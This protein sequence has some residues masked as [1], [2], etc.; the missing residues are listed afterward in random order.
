M[1]TKRIRNAVFTWN[2]Y[3][4]GSIDHLD[5]LQCKYLVYGKEV[6]STGTKHL[7]GY[8]EFTKQLTFGNAKKLLPCCHIEPRKG[9][10]QQAADY[11][12]KDGDYVERGELSKPGKRN[13]LIAVMDKIKQKRKF[14]EI[15]EEHPMTVARHLKF[16]DRYRLEVARS[17]NQF[18]PIEV[19]VFWGPA[20]SGKTKRAY[21]MDPN[22]YHVTDAQ[23]W[24]GYAGQDTILIDDFY[25]GIRYGKFLQLTDGYKFQLP[26]KGGF[27]WKQWKRVIITSNQHPSEWYSLGL[28]DALQ[29]RLTKV[30]E[31]QV[32]V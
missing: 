18:S 13:D 27:T 21:E 3:D 22:L 12:K 17:D 25:G 28:T 10:P 30:E 7:Q 31:V 5:S 6:A 20:G 23:W 26:I 14:V 1:P 11:C 24:D 32:A 29:R 15:A 8:I 9:T 16:Y 19:F 2:N 4:S